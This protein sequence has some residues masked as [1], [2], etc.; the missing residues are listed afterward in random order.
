MKIK[1]HATLLPPELRQIISDTL[2]NG[3][4]KYAES[5]IDAD[6]KSEG[7]DGVGGCEQLTVSEGVDVNVS[8]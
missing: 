2:R 4:G 7:E 8:S 3:V 6:F 1:E 5:I